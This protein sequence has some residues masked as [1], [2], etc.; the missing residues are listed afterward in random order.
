MN[1]I[2]PDESQL[3]VPDGATALTVAETI[4]SRLAKAAVAA[5]IGESWSICPPQSTKA[6]T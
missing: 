6:T 2:L 1:I 4:G 5:K 3:S